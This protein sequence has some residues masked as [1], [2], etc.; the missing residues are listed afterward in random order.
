[1]GICCNWVAWVE[2]FKM[3]NVDRIRDLFLSGR[4]AEATNAE[5]G[6][7]TGIKPHQQVCQITAKLVRSGFLTYKKRGRAKVFFLASREKWPHKIDGNHSVQPVVEDLQMSES[8]NIAKLMRVGFEVVGEW[9]LEDGVVKYRLSKYDKARKILYAFVTAGQ[10]LYIGKSV[11]SLAQRLNGHMKPGPTQST[12][13][14]NHQNIRD[15]LRQ[16]KEVKIL[17]FA[18]AEDEIVYRGIPLNLAAGLEDS[19]IAEIQPLWNDAGKTQ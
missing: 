6:R 15:A 5:I 4:V 16:G 7:L 19:L 10:V 12:N 2:S 14:K 11:R 18:P 17:V 3:T 13:I 1:M 8:E 9:V